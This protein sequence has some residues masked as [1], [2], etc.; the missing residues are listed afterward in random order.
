MVF[1]IKT[2]EENLYK[3][4]GSKKLSMFDF[5]ITPPTAFFG[6]IKANDTLEIYFDLL[7]K[8]DFGQNTIAV[9]NR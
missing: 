1:N 6:L 7:V 3:I 8:V 9:E 5:E 2:L 4:T